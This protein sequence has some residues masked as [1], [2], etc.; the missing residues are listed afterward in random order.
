MVKMAHVLLRSRGNVGRSLTSLILYAMSKSYVGSS[1]E[2]E[3]EREDSLR[4]LV[5]AMLHAS[6]YQTLGELDCRVAD[7]VIELSGSVPS[8]YLKQV[9][10]A[11]VLRIDKA[12]RIR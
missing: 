9:A 6:G 3:Q 2:T 4:E 10:Q 8:F 12:C 11:V 1:V 5:L 7:G